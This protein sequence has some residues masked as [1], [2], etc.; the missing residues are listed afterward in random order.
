MNV[1]ESTGPRYIHLE[2]NNDMVYLCI[3][4]T[5]L[6]LH[7]NDGM[8]S[9]RHLSYVTEI[10]DFYR[11]QIVVKKIL[12]RGQSGRVGRVSGNKTFFFFWPQHSFG[13][14]ASFLLTAKWCLSHLFSFRS[15][16]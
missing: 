2:K 6:P 12:S 3:G 9:K 15:K 10:A 1:G 13:S 4:F 16:F 14:H 8:E 5:I 7:R 11:M